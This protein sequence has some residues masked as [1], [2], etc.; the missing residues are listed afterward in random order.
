M[1]QIKQSTRR[2]FTS[3]PWLERLAAKL[4]GRVSTWPADEFSRFTHATLPKSPAGGSPT[5]PPAAEP[6]KPPQPTS[7]APG[8][9]EVRF[10]ELQRQGRY[11]EMWD[12]LAED[13]QRTWGGRDRFIRSMERQAEEVQVLETEIGAC[14]VVPECRIRNRTYRNVARL[15]VRYRVRHRWQELTLDRQVHLIPAA[16]GWRTLAYPP[17][18]GG[19]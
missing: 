4:L 2:L 17:A 6:L 19:A 3:Y 9:F 1:G 18:S 14:E 10:A 11:H 8:T 5:L 7:I 12:L 15:Q 13:A 16:G